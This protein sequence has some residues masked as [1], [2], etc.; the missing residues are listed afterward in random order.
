M[1]LE[2]SVYGYLILSAYLLC[3]IV[4]FLANKTNPLWKQR[5]VFFS[6]FCLFSWV[7][8][9]LGWLGA[10]MTFWWINPQ[11][12][13]FQSGFIFYGGFFVSFFLGSLILFFLKKPLFSFADAFALVLPLGHSMGRI[14]CA[15]TGCC[16]GEMSAA[17]YS[18]PVQAIESFLLF[19]LFVAIYLRQKKTWPPGSL[20][21][22]YLISYGIIRFFLEFFR[23]DPLRGTFSWSSL[24]FSQM[25]ALH[26]I[27]FGGILYFSLKHFSLG[28]KSR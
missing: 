10:K 27:A 7:F 26:F 21:L 12:P 15:F 3:L 11:F 19:I 28:S 4:F 17:G 22:I 6:G 1:N 8:F 14:G 23:Q 16:Y 24:S 2:F 5:G 13:L 25:I 20:F 9:A 18:I